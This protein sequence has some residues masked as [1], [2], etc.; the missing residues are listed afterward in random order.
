MG[1]GGIKWAW[2]GKVTD[3]FHRRFDHQISNHD[4]KMTMKQEIARSGDLISVATVGALL[5]AAASFWLGQ[6]NSVVTEPYLV[7]RLL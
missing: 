7:R 3:V 2:A 1:K 4:T 5:A 6:V